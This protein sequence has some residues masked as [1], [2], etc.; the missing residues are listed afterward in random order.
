MEVQPWPVLT[1]GEPRPCS[2]S[3]HLRVCASRA[4][5]LGEQSY[6]NAAKEKKW[7][8]EK[9]VASGCRIKLL[10]LSSFQEAKSKCDLWL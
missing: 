9:H 8:K 5:R 6:R 2:K 7:K 3:T 10:T 1:Q 4:L